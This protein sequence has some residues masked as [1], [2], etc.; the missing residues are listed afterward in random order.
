[1][2]K[3]LNA[4]L[5]KSS[6]ENLGLNQTKIAEKLGVSRAAVSK[7]FKGLS[8]PRPAE[9]LKL[10]KMLELSRSELVIHAVPE[11]EPV[12][13]FRK[14]AGGKTTDKHLERAKN[15][16]R[17]LEP[18]VE[19]FDFDHYETPPQ[20][21]TPKTDYDY[22]QGYVKKLREDIGV[23]ETA[24][25]GF[26]DLI[27]TFKKH[28]AVIIPT[29]WGAKSKHE[30]AL[31]VYLP[32]S[33]TTWVY[34]NL[35]SNVHDFKF[36]MAHELGHVLTIELLEKGELELA[37]DFADA[38]AGALL[39][40]VTC[41]MEFFSSYTKANTDNGRIKLL[42]QAAEEHIISPISVYKEL[43]KFAKHNSLA[44]AELP[45]NTL[46]GAV[47][48]FNKK[49]PN[50]SDSLL[51]TKEPTAEHYFETVTEAFETDFFKKLGEHIKASDAGANTVSNILNVSPMDAKAYHEVLAH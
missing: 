18:L 13:A 20:L 36:W 32:K 30:N 9:L 24:E 3:L 48:K 31:H 27:S 43:E 6:A 5:L 51:T 50:L 23:C 29:L 12:V 42:M 45:Q 7:W 11:A 47:A 8:F 35:D 16:G 4:P 41:A 28:Q 49:Y 22:L 34:L 25:L 10:G 46:H 21:K 26:T 44:F 1:M 17:F 37:E 15:M 33:H 40:P 2:E 19:L 14:R 38:F 39:F